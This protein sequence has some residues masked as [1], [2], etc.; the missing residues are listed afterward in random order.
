LAGGSLLLDL[1]G[2]V[3]VFSWTSLAGRRS[4]FTA[5]EVN[6]V[7]RQGTGEGLGGERTERRRII[8]TPPGENAESRSDS[9]TILCSVLMDIN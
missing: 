6:G 5:G 1:A 4:L 8:I 7:E 2:E 9:S 3:I